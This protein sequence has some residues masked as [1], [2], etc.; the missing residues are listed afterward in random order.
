MITIANSP[1]KYQ[2]INTEPVFVIEGVDPQTELI[3]EILANNAPMGTKRFRGLETVSVNVAG[4]ALRTI[5]IE[6]AVGQLSVEPLEAVANIHIR[7]GA[8][9]SAVVPITLAS[10]NSLQVGVPLTDAPEHLAMPSCA[11]MCVCF[12]SAQ[13]PTATLTMLSV[14]EQ[15]DIPLNVVERSGEGLYAATVD[16]RSALAQLEGLGLDSDEFYGA[17]LTI[18]T[19]S[20]IIE[21][22]CTFVGMQG[23]TLCW[24]N[25]YGA[26]DSYTFTLPTAFG[27]NAE[28]TTSATK[29]RKA[30]TVATPLL[31]CE[32]LRW[33]S[34]IEASPKV[35]LRQGVLWH[36]I[37]I[38]KFSAEIKPD[39]CSSA[40]LT[41]YT[42]N[43][44]IRR[45]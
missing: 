36:S 25:E 20:Q 29:S 23:T 34:Q 45:V 10:Q 5:D 35:W 28:R 40:Q 13:R 2:G 39:I 32:H 44:T 1:A 38:E 42:D 6:P 22:S 4:A 8:L 12:I 21:R 43:Q 26:I 7:C 31:P 19:G 18:E 41:I 15:I 33:L 11:T 14:E 3:V 30:I 27:N 24:L 16:F 37:E 9:T 17:L